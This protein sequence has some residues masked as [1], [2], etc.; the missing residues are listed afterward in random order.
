MGSKKSETA[1]AAAELR[2]SGRKRKAV[3]YGETDDLKVVP[4]DPPAKK[5]ATRTKTPAKKEKA[6]V[7]E[8]AE[9]HR[10]DAD[11][12]EEVEVIPQ[13]APKKKTTPPKPK[14]AP[15]KPKKVTEMDLAEDD[16][17][18]AEHDEAQDSSKAAGKK[19][20][21]E[22]PAGEKRLRK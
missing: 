16:D 20:G 22:A 4:E 5:R 3:D 8:L 15:T 9:D 12:E 11:Y 10:D 18:E 7:V 6:P 17:E 19:K 14:K 13:K 21:P 2:R 1:V